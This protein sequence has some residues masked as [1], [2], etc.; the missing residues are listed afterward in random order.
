MGHIAI[1]YRSRY[2]TTTEIVKEMVK[3]AEEA[4][5]KVDAVDLKEGS[6]P[7][8]ITDYDLVIVGSGIQ[9][10]RWTKE[11]LE[12]I[13]RH[14]DKLSTSKVA[15]FVVC[16]DAGSPEY[17][18]HAQSEYL[19]KIAAQYP[20]I[21]FVSTG[22][23]GGMFDFKRY[24]FVTRALVKKIVKARLPEGAEVPDVMDFRDWNQIR[25]WISGLVQN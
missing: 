10:G 14:R 12:F 16:G 20:E 8:P 1:C 3:V 13:D 11:P 15:L 21:A 23:F 6:L 2:G 5:A 18:D 19:D 17:C 7:S 24:N 9:A 25:G 4:G 22:L